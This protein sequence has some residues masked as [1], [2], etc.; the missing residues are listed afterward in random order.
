MQTTVDTTTA[1][2]L[3]VRLGWAD[4]LHH[5]PGYD[6]DG[7]VEYRVGAFWADGGKLYR[8]INDGGARVLHENPA[9]KWDAVR[10]MTCCCCGECVPGKWAQW[11]NRDT[12]FG[13]CAPCVAWQLGRGTSAAEVADLYGHAGI[14]YPAAEVTA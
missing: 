1:A 12:G 14:H 4:G 9:P 11:H 3:N 2:A 6:F 7:L 8:V 5:E 10:R 13:I